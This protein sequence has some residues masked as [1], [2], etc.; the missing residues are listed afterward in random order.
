MSEGAESLE[1]SQFR[2][3]F[4]V[5]L[6]T[7]QQHEPIRVVWRL[8]LHRSRSRWRL[9]TSLHDADYAYSEGRSL[10]FC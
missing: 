6:H 3:L 7:K 10:R 5:L 8:V 1:I 9:T 4:P 2:L